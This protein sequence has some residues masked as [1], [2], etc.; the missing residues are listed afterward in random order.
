[1]TP[2]ATKA[3]AESPK[4]AFLAKVAS[5][6]YEEGLTQQDIARTL[7]YSRSA[8]SRFLSSARENGLVEIRVRHPLQRDAALE[9]E[10][11]ARFALEDIRVLVW[12][13]SDYP[14]MLRRLGA[15]GA[16]IVEDRVRDGT[17][18]GVSWGTAV[19]EVANALSSHHLPNLTVVQLIGAL[20]TPDPE[21]DGGELVRHFARNFGG[22][23]QILP[24]PAIVDRPDVRSM[25]MRDRP[26]REALE[27]AGKVDMAVVGIGTTN[28]SMSSFVRAQY[29][30]EGEIIE[31][32]DT[33]AVGD[34]C[35]IHFNLEGSIL[36]IP[37]AHRVIG[38]QAGGLRAIPYTLAVAGGEIK[39]PAILGAL[40]TGLIQG[41]VTD[42]LAARKFLELDDRNWQ[43]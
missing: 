38:V 8:I 34:V 15:L 20:G 17:F 29:L 26:V 40:R 37:I 11:K 35:A 33:G 22:R 31:I 14:R 7:G 39:P 13:S 19:Y 4:L 27:L 32:A 21:I 6:Y 18:L 42:E 1:M 41:L 12:A 43:P 30:T 2:R 25:L 10:I 28:P 36:D 5:L 16:Q 9:S 24:A 3:N 23:F